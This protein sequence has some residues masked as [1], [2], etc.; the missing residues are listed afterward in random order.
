MYKRPLLSEGRGVSA[1]RLGYR[2]SYSSGALS[3]AYA[4]QV[5]E[6]SFLD[7]DKDNKH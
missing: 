6:L 2:K 1:H 4:I 3:L 7:Y 5:C